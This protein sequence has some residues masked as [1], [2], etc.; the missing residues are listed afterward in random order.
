MEQKIIPKK[1]RGTVTVPPSKS[2]AHRAVIA[3]CLAHGTSEIK[4]IAFSQDISAT[5]GAMEAFGANV[6][7][8]GSSLTVSGNQ[9]QPTENAVIDCAESGSTLRFLI[10]MAWISGRKTTFTG[11]GRLMARPLDPYFALCDSEGIRYECTEST[12]TFCGKL[13]GGSYRL[14]GNISSQFITGLLFALPLLASDSV[15][16]LTTEVESVGYIQMTLD[17]LQS[18]GV[19][20]T[21]DNY[22][23]YYIPGGQ[24]YKPC[25]VTIEGDYSQAAFY[26]CANAMGSDVEVLGLNPDSSQ[27]DREIVSIIAR[28]GEPL[29]G[30]TIDVSQI[31]DLVPVLAVLATQAEGMTTI[32]NAARLRIKESD[33]LKTTTDMLR[34]LGANIEEQEDALVIFGTTPLSGGMVD[35]CNDHRIAMAAA[36]AAT[37]AMGEVTVLGSECVAK[38]Y[39]NFWQ[40]YF[41]LQN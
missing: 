37:V 1:L 3:A 6:T 29:S 15:L 9:P 21:H 18:F 38:S 26:L 41:S 4:N 40:D 7:T 5:I 14:P 27:G 31:P 33:R 39:G 20:V 23:T 36:I 2:Q 19:S 17:I 16:E 8:Q 12:V 24:S 25:E 32:M 10:P 11:R 30:I 22:Q 28:F 13:K 35:A 34:R